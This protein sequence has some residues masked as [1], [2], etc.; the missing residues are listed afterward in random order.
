MSQFFTSDGQ[1]IGASA[2]APV[3]PV[4]IQDWFPLGLTGLISLQSKDSIHSS[5]AAYWTPSDL[6]GSSSCVFLPFHT[7]R[8]LF[9]ARILRWFA[10]SSSSESPI[11]R[12]LHWPVCLGWPYT[13]WL[14]A[15]LSY[16]SPF[17]TTKLWSTKGVLE[18][19]DIKKNWIPLPPTKELFFL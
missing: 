16:S 10:I 1:S 19:Y 11:F 3:L 8:G 18:Y 17:T 9:I 7:V 5:P 13:A 6:R 12:T 14:I 15:S 2:S 4:N